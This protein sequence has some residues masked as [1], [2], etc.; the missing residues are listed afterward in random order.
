MSIERRNFMTKFAE[1][2]YALL[3]TRGIKKNQLLKELHLAKNSINHW[4]NRDTIP[5]GKTL[6][7]IS[8]YFNVSVDFLLGNKEFYLTDNEQL[9]IN[10]YRSMTIEQQEKLLKNINV[11]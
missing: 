9:L 2:L 6:L 1:T 5:N 10:K 11:L 7:S 8:K 3:S 4:E